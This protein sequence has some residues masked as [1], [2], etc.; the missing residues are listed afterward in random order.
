[1]SLLGGILV[2]QYVENRGAFL[3][4]GASLLRPIRQ[5][6]FIA[7]PVAMLAAMIV[8][9][10]RKKDIRSTLTA[11]FSFIGGGGIGNL[12]DRIVHDGKVGDF[13]YMGIGGIRTGISNL[14]DFSIMFGCLLFVLSAAHTPETIL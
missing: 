13:L 9:A 10:G 8:Y 12:L 14:A 6:V 7:S 2:I 11:G 3:S 1:V 4:L 5:A